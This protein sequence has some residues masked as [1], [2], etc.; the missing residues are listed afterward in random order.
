MG[1]ETKSLGTLIDELFTTDHKCWEAQEL[2]DNT[3]F[4]DSA[5]LGFAINAQKLNKRRNE[6]IRA[7]D[8]VFG[9]SENSPTE[10]T[11]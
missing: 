5:R 3:N 9:N 11:Y 2:I 8:I 7:I 6:L 1:I 4:D 10:K